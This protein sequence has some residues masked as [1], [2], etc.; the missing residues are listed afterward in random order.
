M[1]VDLKR[2]YKDALDDLLLAR[3]YAGGTLSQ[4]LESKHVML[5]DDI[6]RQ[7]AP[8]EQAELERE[9]GARTA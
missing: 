8:G 9:L 2:L 3:E 4:E 6:W 1:A 7:L 5:L